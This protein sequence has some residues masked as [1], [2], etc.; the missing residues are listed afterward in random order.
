[1]IL[2]CTHISH[3]SAA[4]YK[5]KIPVME[6]YLSLDEDQSFLLICYNWLTEFMPVHSEKFEMV[7]DVF[8]ILVGKVCD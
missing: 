3:N 2:I 1:M 8:S 5:I 4:R 7:E 6:L